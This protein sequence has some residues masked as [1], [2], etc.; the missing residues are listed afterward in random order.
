MA[1]SLD[2]TMVLPEKL[3]VHLYDFVENGN[4][5][6]ELL[7]CFFLV[8]GFSYD[9]MC[10]NIDWIKK[11]FKEELKTAAELLRDMDADSDFQDDFEKA[12][13]DRFQRERWSRF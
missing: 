8:H 4:Y 11:T 5:A 6:S 12:C 13:N 2:E 9:W 10:E 7:Q 3:R 1:L